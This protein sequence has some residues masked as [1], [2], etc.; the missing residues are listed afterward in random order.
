M[1]MVTGTPEG[2][3]ISQ[4][5]LYIEGSPMIY[6]Q[7]YRANPLNNPDTDGFYWNMSGTT[8]YPVKN[9]GCPLDVSLTEGVTMNDVRCDTVGSKDIIQRRDY[10]ELNLTI[11][12]L[13]P[14][15]SVADIMNLSTPTVAAGIEK[16]GIGAINNSQKWMVYMPRVYDE[17]TG[18][19]LMIHLHKAKFIDAWSLD[20]KSGEAW[21]LSNIKIRAFADDSKPSTA[22]FGTILRSDAAIVP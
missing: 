16:V 8:T 14:I 21:T 1:T 6:F 20:M 2:T 7:D 19:Y 18:E 5:D 17:T 15:T 11:S 9:I 10:I 3:V 4:E 22:R 12:S 13:F